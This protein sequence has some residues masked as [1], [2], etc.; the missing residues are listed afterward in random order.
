[1]R[2][3]LVLLAWLAL[4]L[5]GKGAYGIE[6]QTNPSPTAVFLPPF[7]LS[8]DPTPVAFTINGRR[9]VFP[10]AHLYYPEQWSGGE[11][12]EIFLQALLPEIEPPSDLNLHEFKR[13]GW[14]K[15]ID[16]S[17]TDARRLRDPVEVK[18]WWFG[19]VQPRGVTTVEH[20]LVRFNLRD[21]FANEN[22]YV[23]ATPH[24]DIEYFRCN[25]KD[26]VVISPACDI[27][28]YYDKQIHVNYTYSKDYLPQWREVH[29]SIRRFIA[30][31]SER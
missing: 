20:G 3:L 23:P 14:G 13:A 27:D 31:H 21:I 6:S 16:L 30:E 12:S 24:P 10:K 28:F 29:E 2:V 26:Q 9:L 15:T 8:T 7:G 4:V 1:M 25:K 5:W 17:L 22:L 19:F 18:T 11:V